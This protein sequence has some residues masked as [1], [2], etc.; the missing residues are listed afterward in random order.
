MLRKILK[1]LLHRKG[2]SPQWTF[3]PSPAQVMHM[4]TRPILFIHVGKCAGTSIRDSLLNLIPNGITLH[5]MH[6]KDANE[7]IAE[8]VKNDN[9]EIEYAICTRDPVARFISAFN[10]G[11][12]NQYF[13]GSLNGKREGLGY[14]QFPTIN[15]L[16]KGLQSESLEERELAQALATSKTMHMGMGQ[17]WYTPLEIVQRLPLARTSII[18]ARSP[19]DGVLK[20]ANKLGCRTPESTWDVPW[21]KSDYKLS[22]PD[23]QKAFPTSLSEEERAVLS[24]CIEADINVYRLLLDLQ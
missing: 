7:R 20:L 9:S 8:V 23:H 19:K 12:H 14:D 13:R 4:A 1:P 11:K 24:A 16:V 10:W 5:E 3:N 22:Y 17:S 15:A 2:S 6:C 18:D 21:E